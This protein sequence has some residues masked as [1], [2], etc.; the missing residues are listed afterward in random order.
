LRSLNR[1][2]H[3]ILSGVERKRQGCLTLAITNAPESPLARLADFVLSIEA[4]AELAVL[5]RRLHRGA[6][7]IAMLSAA[8]GGDGGITWESLG[9]SC[10]D[11][12]GARERAAGRR[13]RNALQGHAPV[14][15]AGPRLQLRTAF[16]WALKLKELAYVEAS[17][18]RRGL[19]HGPIAMVNGATRCSR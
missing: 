10:L 17:R 7:A 2:N 12:R 8:L 4:G 11:A 6:D 9:R 19:Q 15:R 3:Q 16:E 1:D 14:R 18:T 5:Q 13:G